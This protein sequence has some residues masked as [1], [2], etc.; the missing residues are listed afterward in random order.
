MHAGLLLVET[1]SHLDC[2]RHSGWLVACMECEIYIRLV[3]TSVQG[4]HVGGLAWPEHWTR[5][6]WLVK[7]QEWLA[8]QWYTEREWLE[9]LVH[10]SRQAFL[11]PASMVRL[12]TRDFRTI[13]HQVQQRTP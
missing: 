7:F 5:S 1:P 12:D 4:S 6:Q 8:F 3:S 10:S 13:V 9:W 11:S 2:K